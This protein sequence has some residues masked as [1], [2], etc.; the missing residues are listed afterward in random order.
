VTRTLNL[1]VPK[2]STSILRAASLLI[3]TAKDPN[4]THA[5]AAAA[6]PYNVSTVAI[7][8]YALYVLA[9]NSEK[10]FCDPLIGSADRYRRLLFILY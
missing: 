6:Y 2:G 3:G 4:A 9:P 8:K 7:V 10:L 1:D 5:T